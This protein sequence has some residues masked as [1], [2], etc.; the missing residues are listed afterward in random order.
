M[1]LRGFPDVPSDK[2]TIE[3]SV[4]RDEAGGFQAIRGDGTRR[5]L[6]VPLA[7]Q[8]EY[9]LVSDAIAAAD[10]YRVLHAAAVA[11]PVGTC[12]VVGE[13]GAGKT[14]LGL[15]LWASGFRLLT[16]DLCPIRRESL[17][18]EAFPRSLHMD[19]LYAPRVLERLP[20][21]PPGFV[22]EYQPFPDPSAAPAPPVSSMLE[23]QRSD[24]APTTLRRLTEAEVAHRLLGATIRPP[25]FDYGAALREM[26]RIA[27]GCRGHV[28][29]AASAEEAWQH[30]R[31]LLG[32]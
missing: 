14:S 12:L 21:R 13:A 19:G 9:L 7:A 29:R 31:A 16:D 15:G 6:R 4:E 10:D 3:L 1:L 24:G 23:L 25:S 20:P 32:S 17:R 28:L 5:S 18:P 2:P 30:A 22:D 11:S 27:S 26:M 8:L